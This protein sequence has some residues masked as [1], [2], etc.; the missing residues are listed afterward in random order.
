MIVPSK[1]MKLSGFGFSGASKDDEKQVLIGY[2]PKE[3]AT[4]FTIE[5]EAIDSENPPTIAEIETYA[6]QWAKILPDNYTLYSAT[7]KASESTEYKIILWKPS[8]WV[9]A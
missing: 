2:K 9:K 8:E 5:A 1:T 4:I 3:R 6:R 7:T